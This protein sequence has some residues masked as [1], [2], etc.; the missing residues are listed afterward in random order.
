MLAVLLAF[1]A[2]LILD[3]CVNPAVPSMG[4]PPK[5]APPPPQATWT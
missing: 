4:D 5:P 1:G 3:A 2:A